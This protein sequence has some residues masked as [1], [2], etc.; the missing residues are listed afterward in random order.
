MNGCGSLLEFS[1]R[2]CSCREF[3]GDLGE[4]SDHPLAICKHLPRKPTPLVEIVTVHRA[5]CS[6]CDGDGYVESWNDDQSDVVIALCPDCGQETFDRE[7]REGARLG[8]EGFV[9]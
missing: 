8:P 9:W 3:C 4:Q 7:I 6:R 2:D 1:R 5:D